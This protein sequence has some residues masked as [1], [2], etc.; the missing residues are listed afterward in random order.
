M[1][2]LGFRRKTHGNCAVGALDCHT[3]ACGGNCGLDVPSVFQ[4]HGDVL[5]EMTAFLRNMGN[6]V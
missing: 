4:W 5:G 1:Y 3:R 2:Y 6:V